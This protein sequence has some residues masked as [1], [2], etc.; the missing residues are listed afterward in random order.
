MHAA[1]RRR[2]RL[3]KS[4]S[5]LSC[6]LALPLGLSACGGSSSAP[7]TTSSTVP[8]STTRCVLITPKQIESVVGTSVSSPSAT[9]HA[10]TT[11][12]TYKATDL[13][14]SVIISYN[15]AANATLFAREAALLRA[16]GDRVGK[17]LGLGDQALYAVKSTKGTTVTT[18]VGRKGSEQVQVTGS[19]T[20]TEL[21]TLAIEALAKVSS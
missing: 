10:A 8:V 17:I 4:A 6:A 12:C 7:T 18:V 20:L 16:K 19:A 3:P 2:P 13:S 5:I 21:E 15:S 1:R 11:L 14:R 9:V